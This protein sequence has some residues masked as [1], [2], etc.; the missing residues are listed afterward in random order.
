MHKISPPQIDYFPC[1]RL[2][3][4]K[5]RSL[6]LINNLFLRVLIKLWEEFDE[7]LAA[8]VPSNVTVFL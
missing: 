2:L 5:F 6:I 1:S 8:H 7:P 4:E 3:I